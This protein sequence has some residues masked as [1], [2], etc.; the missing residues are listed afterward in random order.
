MWV[1]TTTGSMRTVR[2]VMVR[3]VRMPAAEQAP[4]LGTC[5]VWKGKHLLWVRLGFVTNPPSF[6]IYLIFNLIVWNAGVKLL[7]SKILP[8]T[9]KEQILMSTS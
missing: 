9:S 5:T 3:T 6:H 2:K 4:I 8:V 7:G 1:R